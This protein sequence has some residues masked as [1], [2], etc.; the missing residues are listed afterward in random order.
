MLEARVI[1]FSQIITTAKP[2]QT[3]PQKKNT[4]WWVI[5]LSVLG[6]VL[7]LGGAAAVLWKVR[8][9]LLTAK[10]T[11]S[12]FYFILLLSCCYM[13]YVLSR[14]KPAL[15]LANTSALFSRNTQGPTGLQI[16]ITKPNNKQLVNL[17]SRGHLPCWPRYCLVNTTRSRFE[18]FPQKP[19]SRLIRYYCSCH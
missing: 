2:A 14:K 16:Q 5:F 11:Y 15:S 6:G 19:H 13:A 1:V 3:E 12:V 7:L 8:L 10:S 18:I 9:S 17:K 4:P